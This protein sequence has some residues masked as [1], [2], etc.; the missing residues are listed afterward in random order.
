M[1]LL[2]ISRKK[3]LQ[4]QNLMCQVTSVAKFLIFMT[5]RNDQGYTRSLEGFEDINI[6]SLYY[7]ARCLLFY[8]LFEI[9]LIIYQGN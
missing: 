3:E 1:I 5:T 9:K 4:T 7:N 2:S 8:E 6:V